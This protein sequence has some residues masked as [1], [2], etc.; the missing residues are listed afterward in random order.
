M[1]LYDPLAL[2]DTLVGNLRVPLESDLSTPLAYFLSKVPLENVATEGL[3][4]PERLLDIRPDRQTP[5]MGMYMVQPY[6]PGKIPVVMVHGLWSS[7]MTWM[8]MFNDLR[9]IAAIRQRYQFWFY[10]Y[11]T[12]QPFWTSAAELRRDLAEVRSVV[13][14]QHR[15]PALDQMVLV[16]HSMGGLVARMQTIESGDEFWKLAGH[17]PLDQVKTEPE[18]RDKLQSVFY[19]HAN[20]SIRHVVTIAT[21]RCTWQQFFESDYAVSAGQC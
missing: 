3:F 17:I 2:D 8:E 18:V 16:G 13:D 4:Q 12:G 14:P 1:E 19:F 21:C 6:E 5:V 11:P 15:E 7:P 20:P 9:S 10:L